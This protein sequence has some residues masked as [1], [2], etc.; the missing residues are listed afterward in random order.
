MLGSFIA[1]AH[2]PEFEPDSIDV[3]LGYVLSAEYDRTEL[4]IAGFDLRAR[5]LPGVEHMAVCVRVGLPEHAHLVTARI[6]RFVEDR[7]YALAGPSREMFLQPPQPQ[8]MEHSVVEMQYPVQP[9]ASLGAEASV[10]CQPAT[11]ATRGPETR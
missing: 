7:G 8:R 5:E 11:L 6:G 3:E 1:I 10:A 2:S 9:L 4:T